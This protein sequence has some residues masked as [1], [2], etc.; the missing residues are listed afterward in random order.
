M[1]FTLYPQDFQIFIPVVIGLISYL[2]FWFVQKSE[3]LKNKLIEKFGSHTGGARFILFTRYL[4]GF[5]MGVLPAATYLL[6]IP[7]ADFESIGI[8]LS[9]ESVGRVFLLA[10]LIGLII[11]PLVYANAKKPQ[12]LLNYPQIR[13][14]KWKPKLFTQNLISWAVYLLGY[15]ILFRGVLLF[16]LVAAIGIWPAISINIALYSATHIPKGITETLGA[17]PLSLLLCFIC[18]YTGNFWVAFFVHLIMA[19]T[20]TWFSLKNHPNMRLIKI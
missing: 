7:G 13:I 15:E 3:S 19:W 8:T 10:F 6:L 16:P 11:M 5:S 9:K 14:E 4:G 12:N 20:N 1:D 17:I 2:I 18:I